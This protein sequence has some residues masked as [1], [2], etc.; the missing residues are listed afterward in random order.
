MRRAIVHH[1][2]THVNCEAVYMATMF[3]AEPSASR[4]STEEVQLNGPVWFIDWAAKLLQHKHS[5]DP[6]RPVISLEERKRLLNLDYDKYRA[7]T[8]PFH[9]I[10]SQIT[11]I[12]PQSNNPNQLFAPFNVTAPWIRLLDVTS[13]HDLAFAVVTLLSLNCSEASVE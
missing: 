4:L 3:A 13:A 1:W 9:N 8:S 7:K 2:M 6:S 10:Q 5:L 12:R 11:S